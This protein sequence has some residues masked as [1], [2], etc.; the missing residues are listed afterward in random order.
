[1]NLVQGAATLWDG[2][3]WQAAARSTWAA[4]KA[5]ASLTVLSQVPSSITRSTKA[6]TS[7]VQ[8]SVA[9]RLRARACSFLATCASN[10]AWSSFSGT[11]SAIA[12]PDVTGTGRCVRLDGCGKARVLPHPG[13]RTGD[14]EHMGRGFH[15]SVKLDISRRSK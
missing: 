4:T 14:A 9:A 13:N 7:T 1:M 6:L 5:T 8:T 15:S 2:Y 11:D 12:K 3:F 10:A